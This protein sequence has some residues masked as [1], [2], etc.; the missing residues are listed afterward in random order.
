[1]RDTTGP[2][3]PAFSTRTPP[4]TRRKCAPHHPVC[5]PVTQ[6][7]SAHTATHRLHPPP[8]PPREP[9]W[10]PPS[11]GPP[12]P[13][14]SA[15][16]RTSQWTRAP[17]PGRPR[18]PP[19]ASLDTHRS[20]PPFDIRLAPPRAVPLTLSRPCARQHTRPTW[21]PRASTPPAGSRFPSGPPLGPLPTGVPP[22]AARPVGTTPG[23]PH[24][25]EPCVSIPTGL[26]SRHPRPGACAHDGSMTTTLSRPAPFP[27]PHYEREPPPTPNLLPPPPQPPTPGMG[28]RLQGPPTVPN[29]PQTQPCAIP[30]RPRA[31]QPPPAQTPTPAPAAPTPPC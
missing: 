10:V 15:G 5:A 17:P 12:P 2:A 11:P 21:P 3:P 20:P 16:L 18:G 26:P 8:P 14:R 1:M 31:V 9:T 25:P 27:T 22:P 7:Q 4:P 13:F 6:P 28:R 23:T 19:S 30:P 24:D 29:L